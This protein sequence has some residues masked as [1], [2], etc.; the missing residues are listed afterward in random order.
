MAA[1]DVILLL[2]PAQLHN[3]REH[4]QVMPGPTAPT[5]P[6]TLLPKQLNNGSSKSDVPFI[7]FPRVKQQQLVMPALTSFRILLAKQLFYGSTR[8]D[9]HSASC[10]IA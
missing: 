1:Q 7:T 6:R 10:P 8:R 3:D 5:S 2:L 4:I 9:S